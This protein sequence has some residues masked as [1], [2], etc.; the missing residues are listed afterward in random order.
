MDSEHLKVMRFEK[1]LL[2]RIQARLSSITSQDSANA[3]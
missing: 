3:Y 1:C 2:G